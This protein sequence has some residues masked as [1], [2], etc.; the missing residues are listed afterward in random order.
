[1]TWPAIASAWRWASE[2]SVSASSAVYSLP[3]ALAVAEPST[4]GE[5]LR[6][7]RPAG[8]LGLRRVLLGDDRLDLVV[9]ELDPLEDVGDVGEPRGGDEAELRQASSPAMKREFFHASKYS[10]IVGVITVIAVSASDGVGS[11]SCASASRLSASSSNFSTIA[12]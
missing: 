7:A 2:P 4:I 3:V 1:M 5:Q 10:L 8:L 12:T 6:R 11:N 9:G